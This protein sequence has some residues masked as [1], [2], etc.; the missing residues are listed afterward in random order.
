MPSGRSRRRYGRRRLFHKQPSNEVTKCQTSAIFTVST[1]TSLRWNAESGFLAVSAFNGET[2]ERELQQIEL[3]QA[4]TFVMDLA[5]RERGYGLIKSG[6]YRHEVDAGRQPAA[7]VA[8][9]RG[10]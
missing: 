4:A 10:I 2:G 8:R 9:R 3:G 7:A 1:R 5:T 6:V